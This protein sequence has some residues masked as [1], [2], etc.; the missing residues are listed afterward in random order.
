[1]SITRPREIGILL[2]VLTLA[3]CQAAS[4]TPGASAS[5]L[6][7]ASPS[8]EPSASAS[9]VVTHWEQ[10]ASMPIAPEDARAVAFANGSVL[11]VGNAQEAALWNA[12]TGSWSVVPG[13]DTPRTHFA[14]VRLQDDRAMVIGGMNDIDQSYL[15]A[16]VFDP[17]APEA[18]W[19]RIDN[20]LHTARTDPSAVVLADG[21]VLVA[22]GYFRE[23]PLYGSLPNPGIVL[24]SSR[25]PLADVAPEN[26]GAAMATAELFDPATGEWSETGHMTYAR[27]AAPATLLAD[28]RVLVAASQCTNEVTVDDHACR[29]AEVYDPSSESFTLTG[30]LPDM[31][32][33]G[34]DFPHDQDQVSNYPLNLTGSLLPLADGGAAL[35][36]TYG[37]VKYGGAAIRSFR[38][39]PDN[40]T[41][42]QIGDLYLAYWSPFGD[43]PI[44]WETTDVLPRVAPM[45]ALLPDGRVVVAG[46]DSVKGPP[47][48]TLTADLYD[49][50]SDSWSALPPMPE[51]RG[52]GAAVT[53][54]DGSLLM[55]GGHR[56]E[57]AEPGLS[58]PL[59]TAVRLVIG[60]E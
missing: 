10:F 3:A 39:Y 1:M 7:S 12:A 22:G 31:D 59:S 2:V 57:G 52:A 27:Y 15:S 41:W 13:F 48:S 44:E 37:A 53:L 30:A 45:V 50:A 28:G 46:G 23:A 58:G 34:Y 20:L 4:P 9:P 49:P 43:E 60:S 55:V 36:G 24:A 17:T 14:L 8:V 32:W 26:V 56:F 6:T 18:G 19:V 42:R 33:S 38:Y 16:L 35:I 25:G 47:T 29:T 54:P 40:G 11:V 21:R 5:P 51:A